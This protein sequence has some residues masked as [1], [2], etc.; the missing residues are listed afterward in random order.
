MEYYL[1][2]FAGSI[3]GAVGSICVKQYDRKTVGIR[4]ANAAFNTILA[5]FSVLYYALIGIVT[6]GGIVF[7]GPTVGLAALRAVFYVIG[8]FG[9]LASV[10]RGSLFIAIIVSHMGALIPILFSTF[11]YGEPV[12]VFALAG[13]V[14]LFAALALFNKQKEGEVKN[15]KGYWLFAAMSGIGNGFC[16]LVGKVQQVR[17]PGQYRSDFLFW[18]ML[19]VGI[20]FLVMFLIRPPRSEENGGKNAWR[21]STVGIGW[22]VLYALGNA[23]TN[24]ISS[25]TTTHLLAIV[26]YMIGTGFGILLSFLVARCIYRE[27]LS[28]VKYIGCILAVIGLVLLSMGDWLPTDFVERVSFVFR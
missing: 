28:A 5:F 10:S 9:Y 8:S 24:Y 4:G 2:C 26:Q 22:A 14:L 19:L 21:L 20:V 15:E 1:L 13:V 27:K 12:T 3:C 16:M 23:T 6:G 25:V 18:S 11:Y 7:H 17:Y